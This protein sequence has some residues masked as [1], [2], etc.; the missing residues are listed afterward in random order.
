[1][2]KD[3]WLVNHLS[4]L[5]CMMISVVQVT[6]RPVSVFKDAPHVYLLWLLKE[7]V[8]DILNTLMFKRVRYL[9]M[10]TTVKPCFHR[11]L[12]VFSCV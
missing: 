5:C 12:F 11:C 4:Q 3:N 2:F 9:C 1:M 8:D 7:W 6:C 10:H